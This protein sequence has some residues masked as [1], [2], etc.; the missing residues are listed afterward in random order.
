MARGRGYG[1]GVGAAVRR[2]GLSMCEAGLLMRAHCVRAP[3]QNCVDS[4]AV[5]RLGGRR[6]GVQ[7]AGVFS[8][9]AWV[10]KAGGRESEG[11]GGPLGWG[12][13]S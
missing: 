10:G 4:R 2:R 13:G 8:M 11:V 3:E 1:R 5:S 12:E 6:R 7:R 9:G